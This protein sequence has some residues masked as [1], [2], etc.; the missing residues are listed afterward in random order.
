M[1]MTLVLLRHGESTW[2]LEGKFTGWHDV[3]LS[4]TGEEQ[5]REAGLVLREENVLPDVVHT[6]LQK[7]AIRTANLALEQ[8]D[9]LLGTVLSYSDGNFDTLL[10][11]G[12][13]EAIRKE[14]A[15]RAKIAAQESAQRAALPDNDHGAPAQ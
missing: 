4:A 2:N 5:A 10:Q 3:D 15:W 7:R 1:S 6:S 13:A 8:L 14:Q 12:F 11:L 9:R